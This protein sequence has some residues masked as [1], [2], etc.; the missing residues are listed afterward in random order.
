LMAAA[1]ISSLVFLFWTRKA[2]IAAAKSA[3]NPPAAA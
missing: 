1:A 3:Q 2:L